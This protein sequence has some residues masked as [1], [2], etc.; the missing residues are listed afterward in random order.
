MLVC[1]KK[2][3]FGT[4]TSLFWSKIC[5]F[6]ASY[7]QWTSKCKKVHHQVARSPMCGLIL[8]PQNTPN[9]K[10]TAIDD[11]KISKFHEKWPSFSIILP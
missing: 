10:M 1:L 9:I 11:E 2:N 3:H 7:E 5:H 8:E 4:L 6:W